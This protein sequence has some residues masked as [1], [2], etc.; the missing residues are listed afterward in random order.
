[1]E[2]TSWLP[3][4]P[5]LSDIALSYFLGEQTSTELPRLLAIYSSVL[6]NNFAIRYC[7]L[8]DNGQKRLVGMDEGSFRMLLQKVL[9]YASSVSDGLTVLVCIRLAN[10][11]LD[12]KKRLK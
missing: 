6:Q 11:A 8:S 5:S 9:D 4:S 7:D 1:M 12:A 10:A 2:Q 3:A